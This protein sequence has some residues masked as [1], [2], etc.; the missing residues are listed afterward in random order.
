[1][2]LSCKGWRSLNLNIKLVVSQEGCPRSAFMFVLKQTKQKQVYWRKYLLGW[3]FEV[4]GNHFRE[5][6]SGNQA[7]IISY[8][9]SRES[10]IN[11]RMTRV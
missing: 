10:K 2:I 11:V 7:A 1:M 6:T 3:Q 9:Q 8:P 4:I 5:D